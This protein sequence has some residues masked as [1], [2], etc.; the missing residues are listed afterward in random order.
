VSGNGTYSPSA[1]FIPSSA[2]GYW[3]YASY[4]GD[5]F[6]NVANSGCGALMAETVVSAVSL[7]QVTPPQLS[8]LTV[9]PKTFSLS[10]RRVRGRC[11]AQSARNRTDRRCTRPV[12]LTIR[13]QLDSAATVGIT[14]EQLLP[15]RRSRGRCLAQTAHNRKLPS[16]TR[17]TAVRGAVTE[18]GAQGA[19][20]SIFNGKIGGHTLGSGRYL[21]T[22]TPSS[23]GRA[24]T[25][26]SAGFTI[27]S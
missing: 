13:Y 21:L 18:S 24:G 3:W 11:V 12:N 15:G 14:I 26:Q 1:G 23:S 2:G 9:S 16:C 25:A 20:R 7:P 17:V 19:N 8:H 5:S 10:G 6:N 27:T 4:G 22:A